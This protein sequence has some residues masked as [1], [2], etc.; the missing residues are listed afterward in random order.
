MPLNILKRSIELPKDVSFEVNDSNFATLKGPKGTYS[1]ELSDVVSIES[2]D[3][4]INFTVDDIDNK[5]QRAQLGLVKSLISGAIEGVTKGFVKEL[6]IKGVGYRAIVKGS[7]LSLNLGFSHPIEFKIPE[8]ITIEAP[9]QTEVLV[10]G[11]N[12]YLVGQVAANIR[13]YRPVER[14]KGK[15]IRYKNEVVLMKE[16]KKK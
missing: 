15:G 9:S 11:V 4:M 10:K 3:G 1:K 14:Y 13:R 8:G 2:K 12:K 6:E 7:M 16:T 5:S